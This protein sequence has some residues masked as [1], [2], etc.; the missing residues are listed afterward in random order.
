MNGKQNILWIT[1]TAIFIALL[2]VLQAATA[3]LGSSIITGSIVNLLLVVSV[4]SYGLASG[5]A[6]A[7]ISPVIAKL[8]GIGPLWTLIPF[9]ALG[10]IVLVV[11]WY[12]IEKRRTAHKLTAYAVALVCAAIAKFLVLYF[13]IV[14][15]AIPL[16]L[17]L[18]AQQAAVISGMFSFPQLLTALIGGALAVVIF[19]RLRPAIA[20]GGA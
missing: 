8:F 15:V 19:P 20:K 2:V 7:T 4:M 18:P 9:I 12:V 13:G 17:Q 5:L 1:R 14:Q 16:F 3:P 6:V 11:L 10:N